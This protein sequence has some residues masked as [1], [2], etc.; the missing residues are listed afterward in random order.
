M[1]FARFF[2][3]A[4]LLLTAAVAFAGQSAPTL[5]Q[6][7]ISPDGSTLVFVSGG[8][9]WTV[10]ARGGE[11]H[12]L[13]TGAGNASRPLYSPDGK[14]IA[15]VSDKT[16][17]G[18]IY[19][20]DLA[21]GALERLTWADG[22]ETLSAWSRDS[23]WLYFSAARDN[24]GGMN[25]VYR[26][27]TGGGTPMP[28]SFELYR[29]EEEGVPS[30]DGQVIALVGQGWGSAQW[31]RDGHAHIDEGAIWLLSNDGRHHYR[32][33]TPDDARALWPMWSANGHAVYYMSDRGGV[34]NIWRAARAG[35]EQTRVSHFENGRVLWPTIAANG[36]TIAFQRGFGIW[37]LNT[38]TGH[39]RPV[40]IELRGVAVGPSVVHR[41]FTRGFRELAL[42]P[43]GKKLAFVVHGEIFAAPAADHGAQPPAKRVTETPAAEFDVAWAPDSRR[44]VYASE[45]SGH[46]H[47]YMYDFVTGEETQLT[48][49]AYDD[50]H[51]EFSPDGKALA[52]LRDGKQLYRLDVKARDLT[53]LATG[54]ID[55]NRPLAFDRPFTWSPDGEWIAFLGWGSRM[56]RNANVVPA[57]GGNVRPVS[58]LGNTFAD[59]IAWGDDGKTLYFGT[60]Q[61]T[62]AG[63]IARL[64]LVP[65]TPTFHE[66]DF[67]DLFQADAP[68]GKS[69]SKP[70]AANKAAEDSDDEDKQVKIQFT[71]IA[72]RLRLLP[73]GLNASG[74]ALG[75]DGDKMA[76][77][78]E[79]DGHSNLYVYPLDGGADWQ[80]VPRQLTA[81]T[82]AKSDVQFSP[83]GGTIYFLDGGC[84]FTVGANG[85]IPQRLTL[86][87]EMDVDFAAE[88][89]V[90]FDEAWHW[91]RNNFHDAGMNGVN[92]RTVRHKYAPQIAGARTPE[93]LHR[94]LNRMVGELDAS[95]SGVRG[96][97]HAQPVTGRLGLRF[98]SRAYEQHGQFR[99]SA[100]VPLSPAGVSGKIQVGDYLLAVDGKRLDADVNLA[101]MLNYSIGRE[102]KL[103][104]ARTPEGR[105][106]RTVKVKPIETDQ[107]QKLVYRAWVDHNR[108]YVSRI[109]NGRLGYIHLPDMSMASLQRFYQAINAQNATKQ[110]VVIDIRNN[111]GGF[112][113]A[114][115][116]DVLARQP[117]LNMQFRGMT[118]VGARPV[119]GQYALN[120]P[121]VLIT[122][123]VTLS[124]GEDFAQGYRAMGL[125]QIV[126]EPTA[127]WIIYTSNVS[128]IDGATLRLP[129]I[130]VA[131][132]TGQPLEENPRPVD[133]LVKRPLGEAYRNQDSYLDAAV[134]TLLDQIVPSPTKLVRDTDSAQEA[135]RARGE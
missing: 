48:R 79:V 68:S 49:G 2:V 8:D 116:L 83:D 85:G 87:A 89:Q 16:G 82:G 97:R 105:D 7:A 14:R 84:A 56:Y 91:L 19:I 13:V 9:L 50:A 51:P 67:L 112:V 95:H 94:L 30:P 5:T 106:A 107:L 32:R 111:F 55:L 134:D 113:N 127:G 62:A 26:V 81:T 69:E 45:R 44:I 115:A 15:F 133:T 100:V 33:I 103:R 46:N 42:S 102:T 101:E 110:G 90:A 3:S 125:G 132:E 114:Y 10:P 20:F 18:D 96:T 22:A 28:V 64:N 77:I 104:I 57:D 126:G 52:F 118:P 35:G 21:S 75:P 71:D 58:F 93:E 24:I 88:K 120:R 63:Q 37:T 12:L 129:F 25:A 41:T 119:L 74:L 80:P 38:R 124:D 86:S 61:R 36:G 131:D 27:R 6:P 31:W 99:I 117:Y 39:A 72:N 53:L 73:I 65:R 60:G 130:T 78:A 59:S 17:G 108:D 11:A 98:D 123:R 76:V 23:R 135:A 70:D 40:P 128:L 4:F 54:K 121:T 109:S 92:W 34:E 43:D 1:T 122:N 66:D 47:I 29:N